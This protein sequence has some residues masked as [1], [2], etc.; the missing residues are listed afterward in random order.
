[1]T[2]LSRLLLTCLIVVS[3][4]CSQFRETGRAVSE[5]NGVLLDSEEHLLGQKRYQI[6]VRGSSVLFDGQAEQFFNRRAEEYTHSLGCKGWKLISYQA[7]IENTLLGARRYA[8]GVV[9][10]L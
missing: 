5:E 6:T 7:G 4:A 10:C 2:L 1:M 8:Q 3:A 9:E